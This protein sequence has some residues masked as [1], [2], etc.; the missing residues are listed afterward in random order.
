MRRNTAL[1]FLGQEC[2]QLL[3]IVRMPSRIKMIEVTL[4]KA[5]V[6][7]NDSGLGIQSFQFELN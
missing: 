2:P 6:I 5:S 4:G 1:A 7:Q 3:P